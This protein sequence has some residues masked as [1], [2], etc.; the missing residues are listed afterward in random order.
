MRVA[1][2]RFFQDVSAWFVVQM[3]FLMGFASGMYALSGDPET[4]YASV[5]PAGTPFNWTIDQS[6]EMLS[7]GQYQGTDGEPFRALDTWLMSMLQ[8]LE[9][10]L[11]QDAELSCLRNYSSAPWAASPI[12]ISFQ[13]FSAGV[14]ICA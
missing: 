10:A 2:D 13:L 8:L 11:K 5:T 14:L 9:A 12:I 4:A 7:I 3:I 1:S 6:C